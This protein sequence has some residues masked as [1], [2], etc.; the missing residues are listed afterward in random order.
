M[1]FAVDQ[2]GNR[3][4][5]GVADSKETYYC[6]ICHSELVLKNKGQF[7]MEHFAH[8]TNDCEDGWNY[9]MSE[10]HQGMQAIFD[11]QYR[12][13]ICTSGKEKHRADILKDGVVLE[14]QHSPLS[15]QEFTSRNRF[16]KSLGYKIVWVFDVAEQM[17]AGNLYYSD[18]D[19]QNLMIWKYPKQL[20]SLT[21]IV[22]DNSKD[23]ALYFWFEKDYE[24]DEITIEKVIWAI[25][26]DASRYNFSRFMVSNYSYELRKDMDL[27]E[28][29][30]SKKD[31]LQDRLKSINSPYKIKK[32]GEKGFSRDWYVCPRRNEFGL[33]VFHETGCS[34]CR[35]C[36]ALEKTGKSG[37]RSTYNVYCCYPNAVNE[38]IEDC[39]PG[40][41]SNAPI[42]D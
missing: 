27:N 29:F 3:V 25:R 7:R 24:E 26:E 37:Y 38:L 31:F 1:E 34:Y 10:W 11:E 9:D 22:S 36:G 28:L 8:K 14:F 20:L 30:F 16:Y 35:Y 41:E 2:K 15:A 19:N 13:V 23:F 6:P 5:A 12:E 21:P 32:I 40:Y 33:S 17:N 42:F 39:H 18:G 4:W